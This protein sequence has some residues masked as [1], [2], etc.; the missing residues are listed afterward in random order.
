MNDDRGG[1]RIGRRG[2]AMLVIAA[3]IA[4]AAFGQLDEHCTI[5]VFHCPAQVDA[6]GFWRIDNNPA[7]A[8][9]R[10]AVRGTS[11]EVELEL[12]QRA[13]DERKVL[14]IAR[15]PKSGL[16]IW[17]QVANAEPGPAER[18][19]H[20][21]Q[22]PGSAVVGAGSDRLVRITN[23]RLNLIVH[24]SRQRYRSLAAA[25]SAIVPAARIPSTVRYVDVN[26]VGHFEPFYFDRRGVANSFGP[27]LTML[28]PS[29]GNWLLTLTGDNG[30][31]ATVTLDSDYRVIDVRKD[32]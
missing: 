13:M 5:S 28:R 23:I 15:E 7:G 26:L 14:V 32:R 19:F 17:S 29:D 12:R 2:L 6:K 21:E 18:F 4:T 1:T 20:L 31:V 9:I 3:G 10:Y 16:T 30:L 25:E 11:G 8:G 22:F 27:K 24:E